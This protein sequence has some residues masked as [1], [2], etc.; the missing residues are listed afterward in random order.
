M[1]GGADK[2]TYLGGGGNDTITADD[3]LGGESVDCG[4]SPFD[5]N[6]SARVD[7]KDIVSND[8]DKVQG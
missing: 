2:D 6:D 5:G 4:S 7:A 1:I 8:C 3:G